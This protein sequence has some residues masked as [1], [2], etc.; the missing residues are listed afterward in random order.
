MCVRFSRRE[1]ALAEKWRRHANSGR[2][3][4]RL[5]GRGINEQFSPL[6][7]DAVKPTRGRSPPLAG[8]AEKG[9]G[10]CLT[11]LENTDPHF[12]PP[13]RCEGKFVNLSA[14]ILVAFA[15]VED[16]IVCAGRARQRR[17][18]GVSARNLMRFS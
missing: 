12:A 13:L 14:A 10:R 18:L 3:D 16:G 6:F 2:I 4:D 7:A 5:R 17:R 15:L 8:K 9:F 11:F 1:G